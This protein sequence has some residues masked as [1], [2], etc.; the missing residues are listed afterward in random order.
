ME[1]DKRDVDDTTSSFMRQELALNH[2][3]DRKW[4]CEENCE[5]LESD[6][7]WKCLIDIASVTKAQSE[8][9]ERHPNEHWNQFDNSAVS[10]LDF[11]DLTKKH[12]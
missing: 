4:Q 6:Q 7:L 10:C 8:V 5:N 9:L 12:H 2:R 3:H 11:M 1:E